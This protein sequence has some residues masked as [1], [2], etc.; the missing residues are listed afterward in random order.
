MVPQAQIPP[1]VKTQTPLP[2]I[3]LYQNFKETDERALASI[4]A[5]AASNIHLGGD[6][7]ISKN[8]LSE[9]LHNCHFKV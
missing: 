5:L 2:P 6:R 1:F 4:Q 3:D 8:A 7:T 9:F